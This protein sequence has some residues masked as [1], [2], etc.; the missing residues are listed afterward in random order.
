MSY[1]KQIANTLVSHM[2]EHEYRYEFDREEG[3]IR[4]RFKIKG[5]LDHVRFVLIIKDTHYVSYGCI[6]M[7]AEESQRKEV[8]E[9]LTRA[10]FGLWFGNFELDMN[11][12]EIRYKVCVD[13]DHTTLSGQMIERSLDIP[14]AMYQRY[15]D[16]MLKVMFGME[17]AEEAIKIAESNS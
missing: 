12:G 4:L 10:N 13:C 14:I 9:Y 7:N 5:K 6:D 3:I 15:G 17:S 2:E 8:A 1:S 11:D 16:E